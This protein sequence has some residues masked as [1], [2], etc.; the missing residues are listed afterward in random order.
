M[1]IPT[2]EEL[3]ERYRKLIDDPEMEKHL[4]AFEIYFS[5]VASREKQPLLILNNA[6][7]AAQTVLVVLQHV[8]QNRDIPK[9]QP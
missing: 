1:S 7:F 3:F 6:V 2:I 4:E 5:C 8:K 9:V